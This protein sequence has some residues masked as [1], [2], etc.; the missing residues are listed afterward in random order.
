MNS[1]RLKSV[2]SERSRPLRAAAAL[3]SAALLSTASADARAQP[4][5]Q[6]LSYAVK[7]ACGTLGTD[8]ES[9][10]GVY[11]TS[12]Q[13]H[14]PHHFAVQFRKKA[15]LAFPDRS[16]NRGQFASFLD[17]S[18]GPDE[19]FAIDCDDVRALL[20]DADDP[21]HITGFVVLEV[22]D[23]SVQEA[24]VPGAEVG[25]EPFLPAVD[26]VAQ[27]TARD[28][29]GGVSS[30]EIEQVSGKPVFVPR[31]TANAAPRHSAPPARP[32]DEDWIAGATARP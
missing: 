19:A 14:N 28:R 18:L 20:G 9:V 27:Y 24:S 16:A 26:V 25:D 21:T 2:I 5:A 29:S 3:G 1:A 6:A 11:V 15:V 13:V 8:A 4:T 17:D 12:I 7:F 30:L 22:P 10:R 23:T 31:F 32:A